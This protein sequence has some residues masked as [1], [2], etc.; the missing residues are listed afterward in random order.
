M[1][2]AFEGK[3]EQ[4]DEAEDLGVAVSFEE[5]KG[6]FPQ[7]AASQKSAGV[8]VDCVQYQWYC[9]VSGV[10]GW[11][12]KKQ[13]VRELLGWSLSVEKYGVIVERS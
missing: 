5:M 11:G 3:C 4:M 9:P 7:A 2:M 6:P 1:P 12:M 8:P 10:S 13:F